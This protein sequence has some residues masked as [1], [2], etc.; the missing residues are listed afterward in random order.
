MEQKQEHEQKQC[1]EK[2]KETGIGT[3][4]KQA[5]GQRKKNRNRNKIR[6][7]VQKKVKKQQQDQK[8]RSDKGIETEKGIK[9]IARD[10]NRNRKRNQNNS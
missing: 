1:L 6:S 7:S 3:R 10:I 5:L 2:G 4:P 8:Q 9:T